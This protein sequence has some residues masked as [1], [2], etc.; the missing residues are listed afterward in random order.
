MFIHS[1]EIFSTNQ[2][3]QPAVNIQV[4][5]GERALTKDNLQLGRFDLTGIPSAPRGVPQIE[6]TFS[7]DKNGILQVSAIDKGTGK[8]E[9]VTITSEKGRLSESEIEKMVKDAERFAEEDKKVRE[10]VDAKNS[11]ESYLYNLR[12]VLDEGDGSGHVSAE[13]RKDLQDAIDDAIDW[14]DDNSGADIE[15]Y[16]ENKKKEVEQVANPI[17]RQFYSDDSGG[18]NED[19]DYGD[20][21]L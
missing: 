20:E 19:Y 3:N 18:E 7:V 2:D 14:L 11:L 10:R 12:N 16:V 1:P 17:M 21:E 5:E 4:F 6:V 13:D 15:E 8:G 9:N